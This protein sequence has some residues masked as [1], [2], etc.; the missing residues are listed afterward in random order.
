[1]RI[2]V[3]TPEY[4]P[5]VVGGLGRHVAELTGA[6]AEKGVSVTVLTSLRPNDAEGEGQEAA[7][8]YVRRVNDHAPAALNFTEEVVQR[9]VALL[10]AALQLLAEGRRFDL[11]H[12]HDWL[13]A[14]AARTIKHALG[15]PLIATIHATEYGR[16]GGLFNDLQRR[17]SDIEWWLAYEA[18]RVICC[19]RAMHGELQRI[20][21]VPSDKLS[22]I[23][24]GISIETPTARREEIKAVRRRYGAADDE[25]L[26]FF[27][28]RL[29]HE[30]GVD[31]LLR[32]L[33]FVLASHPSTLLVV[34]GKGPERDR[35]GALANDLGVA[36]RVRFAGHISDEE[37]NTL[38]QAAEAAVFPS[39]YEPFGI[40]ALEAMA[41]GAPVVAARAGGLA[42][43]V[44]HGRTGLLFQPGDPKSLAE[45]IIT[46]L[47]SPSLGQSMVQRARQVV[48]ERYSWSHVADET[49]AVYRHV[50]DAAKR[51]SDA[52]AAFRASL[53]GSHRV[54]A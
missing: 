8:L 37:R 42:E 5:N 51:A 18:W 20:F 34:A 52:A 23:P 46:L 30:K 21:Q 28:G 43:V 47:D 12:A 35:L 38:Y 24:N 40:V 3:L 11:V 26:L 14:H 27:V 29:V 31:V 6:L 10:Q 53:A 4:P 45:Q 15:I 41:F 32:A 49:L 54:Y 16:Y 13:T 7:G 44:E 2:L 50:L 9:N 22:I 25:R 17:I 36:A 48:A 19:S 33:P 1:M 39:R